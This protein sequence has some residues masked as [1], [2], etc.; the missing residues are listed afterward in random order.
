MNEIDYQTL[1]LTYQQKSFDLFSQTVALEARLKTSSK[2]I[3]EL[4]NQVNQLSIEN[5]KLKEKPKTTTKKTDNSSSEE[6]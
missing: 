5:A 1:V 6:F 3:E 2:R 4:T